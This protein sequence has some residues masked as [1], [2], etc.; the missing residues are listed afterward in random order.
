M[1][2]SKFKF[3]TPELK[4]VSFLESPDFS[5]QEYDGML[6]EG[7]T[8]I[9]RVKDKNLAKVTLKVKIGDVGNA[10]PFLINVE[11]TSLFAWDNDVDEKLIDE[12]LR[13]NA[14]SLILSYIRP[15]VSIITGNSRFSAFN[16]PFMN[17][18]DNKPEFITESLE[19]E[20][21]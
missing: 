4:S 8:E 3:K 15:L 7:K 6:F 5:E 14:P 12:L 1:E 16:I 18:G 11:M 13:V 21:D 17:M 20:D 9:A 10:Y 19:T 2:K